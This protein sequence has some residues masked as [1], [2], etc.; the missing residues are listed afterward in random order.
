MK[1]VSPPSFISIPLYRGLQ[2]EGGHAN[3]SYV[4]VDSIIIMRSSVDRL[5]CDITFDN[6]HTHGSPKSIEY[7]IELIFPI[8]G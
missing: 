3:D 7:I 8:E 5:S 2:K 4:K 6:G 1:T